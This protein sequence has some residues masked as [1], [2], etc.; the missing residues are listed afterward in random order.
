MQQDGNY[1][2]NL[3]IDHRAGVVPKI[4]SQVKYGPENALPNTNGETKVTQ[5]R[6]TMNWIKVKLVVSQEEI[7]TNGEYNQ[8]VN[9]R[10]HSEA[11]SEKS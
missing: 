10:S 4:P 5:R 9:G 2:R 7:K 6:P 1:W 3:V 11:W 8:R